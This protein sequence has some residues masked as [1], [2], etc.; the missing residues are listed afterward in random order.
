MLYFIKSQNYLKIGYSQDFE[1]LVDRMSSYCT[2]NPNFILLSFTEFGTTKDEKALHKLL[3]DFQYYTEWFRDDLKVF[4]TWEKYIKDKNLIPKNCFYSFPDDMSKLKNLNYREVW[5]SPLILDFNTEISKEDEEITLLKYFGIKKTFTNEDFIRAC[6]FCEKELN[7]KV[8]KKYLE[9]FGY[10][11][12][13][14][15]EVA[16]TVLKT[17]FI[18]LVLQDQ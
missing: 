18:N 12:S 6:K 17:K 15:N 5:D 8:N 16:V 3:K 1:T 14:N 10:I 2:H 4:Q 11:L 13:E 9:S 7:L